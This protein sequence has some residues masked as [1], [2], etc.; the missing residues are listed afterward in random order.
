MGF[1][2]ASSIV[3]A[4]VIMQESK[5]KMKRHK[6]L[7]AFLLI[8]A[9]LTSCAPPLAQSNP[10]LQPV[11]QST[12]VVVNE[13][14]SSAIS[15]AKSAL[16][17]QLNVGTGLIQLVSIKE[18]QWPDGCLGVQQP[19]IMCAMHVVDGYKIMLSAN[20]QTYETR[21]NLDGSQTVVAPDRHLYL[22]HPKHNQM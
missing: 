22:L 14:M 6:I 17:K 15:A 20:D 16:A 12:P 13:K 10:T 4:I 8:T 2:S 5:R 3:Y 7:A 1:N 21:S 9:T 11:L 19:G 18:V